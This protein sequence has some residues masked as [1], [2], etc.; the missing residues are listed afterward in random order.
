M[1][2]LLLW[3]FRIVVTSAVANNLL[4]LVNEQ[5]DESGQITTNFVT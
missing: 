3:I 1:A 4:N 2:F 5:K